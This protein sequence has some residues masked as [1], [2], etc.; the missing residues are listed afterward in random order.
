MALPMKR[1]T[2]DQRHL[3]GQLVRYGVTGGFV[4]LL[5]VAVYTIAVRTWHWHPQVGNAAAYLVG[6]AT[7]YVLHSR[8][9]FRGSGSGGAAQGVKFFA[10]SAI[11]Y[12]LNASWVG[13]FTGVLHWS[14]LTPTLAMVFLTPPICFVIY[15]KW[16]FA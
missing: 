14:N 4:T 12:G 9:S 13:L 2:G 10:T 11:S 1:L 7:G 3:L 6:V 16:V 5:S 8:F 15:R